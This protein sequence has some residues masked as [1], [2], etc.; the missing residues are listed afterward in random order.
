MKRFA[1]RQ[2]KPGDEEA[3]N[4]LYHAVTHRVRTIEEHRWQWLSAPAGAGDIWLI[5]EVEDRGKEKLIG[6][7]GVMPLRFTHGS[8]DLL[9]GKI[10]NTMVLPDYRTKILYPRFEIQFKQSYQQRYHAIFATMGPEAAIRVRKAGGFQFPVEWCNYRMR[11]S[12]ASELHCATV[13]INRIRRN[14]SN[15]E[16]SGPSTSNSLAVQSDQAFTAAGFMKGE[17]AGAAAFFQG[18]WDQARQHHGVAPRRDIADLR[19]RFWENPYK[20]HYTFVAE[21]KTTCPAYAIVSASASAGKVA[22]LED[23][24]VL[25]PSYENYRGLFLGLSKALSRAGIGVLSVATTNDPCLYQPLQVFSSGRLFCDR[26]IEM[27]RKRT[28]PRMPRYITPIGEETGL[29]CGDWAVTGVVFE[30]R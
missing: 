16:S 17:E 28:P 7:H 13:V 9:F 21:N 15:E 1:F 19:W 5:H 3:I 6:H 14:R 18:F 10:E 20:R 8:Q 4:Q 24:A 2:Y 27:A 29:E 12:W 25:H 11:T 26:L 30:G 23:Y 22:R